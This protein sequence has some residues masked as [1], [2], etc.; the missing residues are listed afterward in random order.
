MD[1][2]KQIE[3]KGI[4]KKGF[5][6]AFSRNHCVHDHQGTGTKYSISADSKFANY[7]DV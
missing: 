2:G 5:S 6:V 7:N 1:L 3:M 4:I